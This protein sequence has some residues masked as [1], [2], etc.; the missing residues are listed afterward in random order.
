VTKRLRANP[1][2][3]PRGYKALV[4]YLH[5]R[6]LKITAYLLRPTNVIN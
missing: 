2:T 4:D 5:A 1:K 3:W 6:K